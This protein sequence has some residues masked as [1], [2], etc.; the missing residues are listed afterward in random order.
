AARRAVWGGQ[1]ACM[2]LLLRFY[3]VALSLPREKVSPFHK[4]RHSDFVRTAE[5]EGGK[6]TFFGF[7][8]SRKN[9]FTNLLLLTIACYLVYRYAP[10]GGFLGAIYRNNALT[11]AALVLGFFA[12]DIVGPF[13]L[14]IIIM[15]LSRLR[16]A[17][18]FFRIEVNP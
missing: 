16:P 14:K 10:R 2:W 8:S 11:T 13:L 12:A 17:A 9:L 7:Q 1:D 18:I 3:D 4:F 6:S 5:A 15:A